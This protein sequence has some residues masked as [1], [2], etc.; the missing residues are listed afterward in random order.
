L[1][2]RLFLSGRT[3]ACGVIFLCSLGHEQVTIVMDRILVVGSGASGVQF[4]LSVLKKGYDVVMLDVGFGKPEVVEPSYN[5]NELKAHLRDPV[6]YFLGKQYEAVIFPGHQSEYYGFPPNKSYVFS[7]PNVTEVESEG[8]APLLSFG[9]GGL[10]EAWTGGVYPFNDDELKYFPFDY[11][12]IEP[13]YCE[14][15]R[16]IGI[17]GEEDD[18][19]RFIPFHENIQKP[20]QLDLHSSMMFNSYTDHKAYLNEKLGSYIGRSR[21][22]VL[23]SDEDDRQAC[24]YTGRC[25]WGCPRGA[26]YTPMITLSECKRYSNFR[27]IPGMYVHYFKYDAKGRIRSIVAESIK[28]NE[29]EEVECGKLILAAGTFSTSRIF[30]ESIYKNSGGVAKLKG[31][32]D[33][34]QILLPYVNW[35]MIGY[36]WKANSYQYHQLTMGVESERPEEYI[37]SQITTLKT[38]MVHP[39]VQ[40]IPMDFKT[41]LD[42]FRSIH[43]ALG[44]VNVNLHDTR[45]EENYITLKNEKNSSIKS[46]IIK[47]KPIN[48]EAEL[49]SKAL[50]T[51]KKSLRALGCIALPMMTHIR[52]KGASVHYAGTIP[53]SKVREPYKTSPYCQSYDFENLYIVD[54][55]TFPFLP[56]KNITFTLMA[57]AIRVADKL[58]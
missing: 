2:S 14:I 22:A 36:P 55:T 27:Y 4:A 21:I 13:Y 31:L 34:R 44:I 10:A 28:R 40:R 33:N 6:E 3:A 54:G 9:Q 58:F 47:Y 49:I 12:D 37:H 35:K 53:M 43:A 17:A 20:L 46:T 24:G 32:M 39:I 11:K 56:A 23:S 50:K 52:P 42:V 41:S 30:L 51:V 48:G 15:A 1:P 29:L 18:L 57:N 5:L 26:L 19:A 38:A 25:L 8:F 16:R 45:R 7:N